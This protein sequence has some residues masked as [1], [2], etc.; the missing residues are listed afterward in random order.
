MGGETGRDLATVGLAIADGFAGQAARQ[1]QQRN[2][3]QLATA[4][5]TATQLAGQGQFSNLPP[6]LQKSFER[7]LG[8]ELVQVLQFQ[9]SINA[10]LATLRQGALSQVQAPV[11][12]ITGFDTREVQAQGPPT[13]QGRVPTQPQQVPIFGQRPPTPQEELRRFERLSPTAA[14]F[15]GGPQLGNLQASTLSALARQTTASSAEK[16]QIRGALIDFAKQNRLVGQVPTSELD[17]A[18]ITDDVIPL[19]LGDTTLLVRR[20]QPVRFANPTAEQTAL[21][22]ELGITNPEEVFTIENATRINKLKLDREL[23]RAGQRELVKGQ[24]KV[25]VIEDQ[26]L[27]VT[28]PNHRLY[29]N[30][31]GNRVQ[32]TRLTGDVRS[33]P[34]TIELTTRQENTL[35]DLRQ[36]L[37]SINQI[38]EQIARVYGAGG[39]F[40]ELAPDGRLSAAARGALSRRLQTEPDLVE[41]Q[42]TLQAR[43]PALLRQMGQVG[44]LSDRDV[45]RGEALLA[46][47]SGVPDTAEQA[48][49]TIENLYGFFNEQAGL[50]LNN[51]NFQF[52]GALDVRNLAA[53]GA[54]Q[55]AGAA[56]RPG[57]AQPTVTP[58][59]AIVMGQRL[60]LSQADQQMM[61]DTVRNR[62]DISRDLLLRAVRE[63]IQRRQQQQQGVPAAPGVR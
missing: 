18:D 46:R 42:R 3:N 19:T 5:E 34:S 1:V 9:S 43:L 7:T 57:A 33:D 50:I 4:T 48:F 47:V 27:F 55:A 52:S 51:N 62:P 22:A 44:S 58:E 37:A 23:A 59:Q 45:E 25:Q 40:E 20:R 6:E 30:A 12:D 11:T 63:M 56:S 49:R 28:A 21:A 35:N 2:L 54:G 8:K 61:A 14:S 41:L 10:P 39:I 24:T 26:P 16:R 17:P 31:T 15:I 36:G 38:A 60:G 32:S 29:N 13:A 53:R